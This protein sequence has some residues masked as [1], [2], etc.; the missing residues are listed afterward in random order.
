[1]PNST[2]DAAAAQPANRLVE[3]VLMS[4]SLVAGVVAPWMENRPAVPE[5]RVETGATS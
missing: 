1:M 4:P 5:G 2:A 3:I